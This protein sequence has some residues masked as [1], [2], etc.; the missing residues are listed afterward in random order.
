MKEAERRVVSL[1]PEAA[2]KRRVLV[3]EDNLDAVHSMAM[4]IKTM[5]HEVRFA[6][7]GFA[8]LE[9]A[10]EF[11][12]EV[13]LLDIGLPDFKGYDIARQLKWEPGL[14]QTR[15]IAISGHSEDEMRQR[16][17]EAGCEDL[18]VKP[19]NPAT[20]EELLAAP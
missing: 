13:I 1:R 7:N 3:V 2:A 17:V 9:V 5:G 11:R 10:R 15:M 12:P 19:L 18:L 6:I 14:E 4:L 16:A 20:M 8:A